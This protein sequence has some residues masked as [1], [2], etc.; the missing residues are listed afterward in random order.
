MKKLLT[1]I[2][3]SFCC[4]VGTAPAKPVSRETAARVAEN[5]AAEL[6]QSKHDALQTNGAEQMLGTSENIFGS[7]GIASTGTPSY[8]IFALN[9]GWCVVS[10]D[11]NAKPV[12]AYSVENNF[13]I[14][15]IPENAKYWF[16]LYN[17]EISSVA[18]A[19]TVRFRL[20]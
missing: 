11:D 17:K 14:S 10:G 18:S 13:S 8:Y 20:F 19:D 12:L 1:I 9:P 6:H 16:D 15:G 3:L 5:F 4:I 7:A 2:L